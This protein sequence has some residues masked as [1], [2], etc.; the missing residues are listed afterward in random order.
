[1]ISLFTWY[2]RSWLILCSQSSSFSP[3]DT[4]TS[5]YNTSAFLV[6]SIASSVK[7]IV[8][9]DSSAKPL[10][11]STKSADGNSS[12]GEQQVKFTPSFEQITIRELATLFLAS[13]KNT[14]FKPFNLPKFS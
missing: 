6:P 7:V 3:I 8:A 4:Q 12:F 9:P 14:S 1:M 10:Q 2:G 11:V 5:V 13:P